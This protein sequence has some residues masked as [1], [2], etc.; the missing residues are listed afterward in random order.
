[1]S[2]SFFHI[3]LEWQLILSFKD[4]RTVYNYFIKLSVSYAE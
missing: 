3:L 2:M 1:M 4:L